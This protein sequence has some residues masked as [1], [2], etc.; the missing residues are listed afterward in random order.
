MVKTEVRDPVR[1][2]APRAAFLLFAWNLLMGGDALTAQT[3]VGGA[4]DADL[5]PLIALQL[6]SGAEI[7]MDGRL[8]EDAWQ[9]AVPITDFATQEP[10]EGGTPSERTEIRVVYD[11][12]ALYIGAILFD[13]PEGILAFQ[14]RR[15]GFLSTDDRFMWILDTFGDGRTGYFFETNAAGVMG[16]A[17]ISGGAG[18]GR[19]GGGNNG[20]AWDGIWQVQSEIRPD[21]WSLEIQIPFRTLNFDPTSDTWGINFQR[22][23]RRRNEEILWRGYR[24]NQSLRQPI[25]AGRLTGLEG[26]SQGIGLEAVPYAVTSWK[27]V[28]E[29]G[30]PTT[31]PSDVGLDINYNLTPSLRAGVSANTDFAEAEVDQRRLNLT[32]F[33]LRFPEQRDFFLEGSGVFAFAPGNEAEPYFSRRIGLTEGEQIPINYAAR[34]GGQAGRYELGFIH[35]NTSELESADVG[36]GTF[37]GEQFTV[38]RVKRSILEQSTIGAIYTHRS[39]GMDPTDATARAPRDQHTAGADLYYGTSRLFGDKNFDVQAF[40]V[41]NSNPDRGVKRSAS[42]LSARGGRINYPND[43]W[44]GSVAYR[45]FGDAY[46]PAVGFVFRKGFRLVEPRIGWQPRPNIDGIR[47]FNFSSQFRHLESITTGIT[48]EEQWQFQVFG[49][50][51]ES[52]EGFNVSVQRQ[53]EFLDNRFEISEGVF[54]EE[55][56]YTNWEWDVFARTASR[57]MF[58]GRGQFRRGGFWSGDR[59]QMGVTLEVRPSPGVLVSAEVEN[60][61]VVLPQGSF[62]ARLFRLAGEW[63]IT[64]LANLTG[65]IQY[66]DVSEVV[67]LFMRTRWIVTP[68]NELFLVFTQNW[69]NLGDGLF[70]QDREFLTLSRGASVKLNYTYRL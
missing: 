26:M 9:R 33:P 15:D 53:F 65:N 63:N 29:E 40:T 44:S 35:V 14:K 47:R 60:N 36:G 11:E 69:Q 62:V 54:I 46:D 51:F 48:E 58:S 41:W 6:E 4:G 55:G 45:E 68:G 30:D 32:R 17:L 27:N 70:D 18:G 7:D 52:Q 50:D 56:S 25:H 38:A 42:D 1:A 21:G 2:F 16:D 39:T 8:D 67:G 28:P 64:P 31:Y 24:R 66:D 37:A 43:I 22:T 49:V 59:T 13:D 23:I 12:D 20:R 34:L 19:G 3:D 10:V 61:D 5:V 57:R